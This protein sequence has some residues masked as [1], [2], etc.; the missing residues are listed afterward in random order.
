LHWNRTTNS[1]KPFLIY[2]LWSILQ[3]W[4]RV[5]MSL[6]LLFYN[7]LGFI[8]V[9]LYFILIAEALIIIF[10]FWVLRRRPDQQH[11]WRT[12]LLFP[13]YKLMTIVSHISFLNLF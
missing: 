4:V 2:E 9:N 11:P 7:P 6:T 1:I 10:N 13:F 5:P 8:Q 12:F 3:D